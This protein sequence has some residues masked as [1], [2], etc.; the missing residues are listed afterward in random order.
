MVTVLQ[1]QVDRTEGEMDRIKTKEDEAE[2]KY[3]ET[4]VEEAKTKERLMSWGEC[5]SDATY[6]PLYSQLY[7]YP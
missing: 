7:G 6:I 3:E 4:E 5:V 2:D 1:T